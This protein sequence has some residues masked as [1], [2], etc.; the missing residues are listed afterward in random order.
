MVQW[1]LSF[2]KRQ[3]AS[4][5]GQQARNVANSSQKSCAVSRHLLLHKLRVRPASFTQLTLRCLAVQVRHCLCQYL[6]DALLVWVCRFFIFFLF[7]FLM[8]YWSVTTFCLIG[9][10]CRDAVVANSLGAG[11]LLLVLLTSGFTIAKGTGLLRFH[12]A[13]ASCARRD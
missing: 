9:A 2:G 10:C 8:H 3:F 11:V 1:T 4:A 13:W 7:S 5:A 6:L 12:Q